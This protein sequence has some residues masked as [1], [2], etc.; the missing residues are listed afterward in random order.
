M[1]SLLARTR[2]HGHAT[3]EVDASGAP[4]GA[5]HDER[6]PRV[7]PA[8]RAWGPWLSQRPAWGPWLHRARRCGAYL[9]VLDPLLGPVCPPAEHRRSTP[10]C[11]SNLPHTPGTIVRIPQGTTPLCNSAPAAGNQSLHR[12]SKGSQKYVELTWLPR[13]AHHSPVRAPSSHRR[14]HRTR[15]LRRPQR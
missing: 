2:G 7:S 11:M 8:G 15:R 14:A 4:G 3:A 12:P 9:A 13:R 10:G 5:A 1:I 6:G